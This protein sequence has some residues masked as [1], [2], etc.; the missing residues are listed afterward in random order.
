MKAKAAFAR[1]NITA[2][3]MQSISL[4]ASVSAGRCKSISE[5]AAPSNK[6]SQITL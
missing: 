3:S 5:V 6:M 2:Q 1:K 4:T